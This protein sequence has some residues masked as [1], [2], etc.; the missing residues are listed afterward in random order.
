MTKMTGLDAF[1]NESEDKIWFGNLISELARL[2]NENERMIAAA[3]LS[4]YR[5]SKAKSDTLGRQGFYQFDWVSGFTTNEDFEKQCVEFLGLLAMGHEYRESPIP[6]EEGTFNVRKGEDFLYHDD[7][8]DWYGSYDSFY[9]RRSELVNFFP[10]LDICNVDCTLVSDSQLKDAESMPDW[11]GKDTV[12][13]VLAAMYILLSKDPNFKWGD[14]V[15]MDKIVKEISY[16]ILETAKED[17]SGT[18]PR[19][20]KKIIAC[21]FDVLNSKK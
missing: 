8:D 21:A 10:E 2:N 15:S 13:R 17:V 18:K 3:I 14:G 4:N 5:L 12:M 19:N 20:I 7:E 16:T 1:Y 6:G 11:R 9:F